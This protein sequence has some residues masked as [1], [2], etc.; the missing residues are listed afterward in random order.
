MKKHNSRGT[1]ITLDRLK[2]LN[3]ENKEKFPVS[4]ID[5]STENKSGT[6]VE[7]K[8]PVQNIISDQK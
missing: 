8:I 1:G 2:I 4:F 6:R 5:K 7:I 3:R